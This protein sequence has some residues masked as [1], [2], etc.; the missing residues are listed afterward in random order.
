[1]GRKNKKGSKDRCFEKQQV[2]AK[3]PTDR[4][5]L[6][7]FISAG[8]L[9]KIFQG[10]TAP[11]TVQ[12]SVRDSARRNFPR[13]MTLVSERTSRKRQPDA[14]IPSGQRVTITSKWHWN[15]SWL[16]EKWAFWSHF[17]ASWC[18]HPTDI[19]YRLGHQ[20]ITIMVVDKTDKF[21]R[22]VKSNVTFRNDRRA[23]II[24][25]V[26]GAPYGRDMKKGDAYSALRLSYRRTLSYRASTR[27]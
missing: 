20:P 27:P 10:R 23:P 22:D 19:L 4:R 17:S 11:P 5:H 2:C 26:S 3:G 15:D 8:S 1:M 25:F 21:P 9:W 12:M 16:I 13:T 24:P 7:V 18:H 6:S 14:F